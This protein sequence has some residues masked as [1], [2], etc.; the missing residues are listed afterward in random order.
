MFEIS[1]RLNWCT[2]ATIHNNQDIRE[3]MIGPVIRISGL[4][5]RLATK[6]TKGFTHRAKV[7]SGNKNYSKLTRT[8]DTTGPTH[9]FCLFL[10]S[11]HLD[12]RSVVHGP[13]VACLYLERQTTAVRNWNVVL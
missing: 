3:R 12:G 11:N 8:K 9:H 10:T 6:R 5:R 4:G 13:S 2:N 7:D 1:K